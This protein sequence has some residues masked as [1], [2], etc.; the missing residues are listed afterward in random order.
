MLSIIFDA[1]SSIL[2]LII[3]IRDQSMLPSPQLENNRSQIQVD[4]SCCF[5]RKNLTINDAGKSKNDE[6]AKANFSKEQ[7]SDQDC[8]DQVESVD[9]DSECEYENVP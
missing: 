5:I 1:E 8:E 6:V 2:S 9:T 7:E 4:C 3:S